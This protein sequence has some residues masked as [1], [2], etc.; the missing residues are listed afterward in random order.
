MKAMGNTIRQE[1]EQFLEHVRWFV[2]VPIG[3][4]PLIL[5]DISV[6]LAILWGIAV[7]FVTF[8]QSFLGGVTIGV[9]VRTA[10]IFAN[11]LVAFAAGA[12]VIVAFLLFQ[13]HYIVLYRFDVDRVYSESMKGKFF[14]LKDSVHWR[15]FPADPVTVTSKRNVTKAVSWNNV[16]CYQAVDALRTILLKGERGT[17]LRI[18]C[19]NEGTYRRAL[20]YIQKELKDKTA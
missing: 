3:T 11:Y 12:F 4:N 8:V 5:W 19:P 17:L 16:R 20:T 2:G 7:V 18:Y 6:S 14:S 15:P 9:Y 13:N 1:P 10:V